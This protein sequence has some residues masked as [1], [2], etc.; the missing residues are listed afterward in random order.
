[1]VVATVVGTAGGGRYDDRRGGY[2]A[3][4]GMFPLHLF[5][6]LVD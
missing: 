4:T 5:A 1:M 6:G 3:V 2:D